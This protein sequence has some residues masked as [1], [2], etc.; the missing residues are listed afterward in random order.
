[1][2]IGPKIYTSYFFFGVTAAEKALELEFD[3]GCYFLLARGPA[4]FGAPVS[5]AIYSAVWF[6]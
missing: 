3:K 4:L 1:M 6:S 5:S 2:I